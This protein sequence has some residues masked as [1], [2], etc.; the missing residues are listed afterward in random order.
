MDSV[1]GTMADTALPSN[2]EDLKNTTL[3]FMF[4]LPQNTNTFRAPKYTPLAPRPKSAQPEEKK[5]IESFQNDER[6]RLL[7]LLVGLDT[8]GD[9][10]ASFQD[11]ERARLK[12]F[13][14]QERVRLEVE[15]QAIRSFQGQEKK[16]LMSLARSL[17]S[18]GQSIGSFQEQE[19]A[20]LHAEL[21]A[22]ASFQDQ[23]RLR[24]QSLGRALDAGNPKAAL[25][26]PFSGNAKKGGDAV[27]E[28]TAEAG[29]AGAQEES[30]APGSELLGQTSPDVIRLSAVALVSIFVGGGVTFAVLRSCSSEST[31]GEEP[32]LV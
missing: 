14:D 6:I 13:Q 25:S 10:I 4:G 18:V 7:E 27:A 22:L 29:P 5:G 20:R 17:N 15:M 19:R 12:S 8:A 28:A 16:R 31:T 23:E 32:L 24:L 21:Q 26:G 1:L 11:Q 30:V 2:K 9:S 3:G